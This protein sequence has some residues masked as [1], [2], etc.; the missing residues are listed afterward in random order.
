M[1]ASKALARRAQGDSMIWIYIL[2][3]C[4]HIVHSTHDDILF[5]QASQLYHQGAYEQALQEL[6][7]V[8]QKNAAVWF[9]MGNVAYALNDHLHAYLYWLRAQEHGN[10][11][12]FDI[13][14]YNITQLQ[15]SFVEPTSALYN[16]LWWLSKY[17]LLW[18]LICLL[19]WYLLL[20]LLYAQRKT[21]YKAL[22]CS[23][24]LF[25][26]GPIIVAYRVQTPRCMIM[27]DAAVYNGPNRS[28]YQI[29]QLP[30]GKLVMIKDCAQE[31]CKI[32]FDGN[33]GWIEQQVV[34]RI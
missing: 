20:Y 28:F 4:T 29:A 1:P 13:A 25:L 23:I 12:I 27:Q 22:L 30:L 6:Q 10:A 21:T 7:Q 18:Q 2:I 26:V 8:E 14:T 5:D 3:F 17:S 31:W 16:W 15:D 19:L 34:E 9:N 24:L 32:S 11:R 33:I